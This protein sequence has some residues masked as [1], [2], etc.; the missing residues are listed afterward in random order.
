MN[1]C[2][3]SISSKL[4]INRSLGLKVLIYEVVAVIR[5]RQGLLR[6]STSQKWRA[7]FQPMRYMHSPDILLILSW[8]DLIWFDVY[9]E[10]WQAL[11]EIV[12][13]FCTVHHKFPKGGVFFNYHIKLTLSGVYCNHL[14]RH[15]LFLCNYLLCSSI[16]WRLLEDNKKIIQCLWE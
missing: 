15:A 3:H 7:C 16:L 5:L 14:I 9:P 13:I 1:E 10:D 12:L 6:S 4:D 2:L 11:G 8:F